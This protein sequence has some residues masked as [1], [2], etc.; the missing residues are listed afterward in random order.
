MGANW[1]S[2][3]GPCVA[4]YLS[5]VRREGNYPQ[6]CALGTGINRGSAMERFYIWKRR[7]ASP[8]QHLSATS[9]YT[10]CSPLARRPL[11]FLAITG[12]GFRGALRI[13]SI[14]PRLRF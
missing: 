1:M 10:E 8:R 11:Q 2:S 3:R 5:G 12:P 9:D 13:E 14:V 7:G 4:R 6:A